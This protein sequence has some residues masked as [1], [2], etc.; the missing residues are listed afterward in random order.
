M[1]GFAAFPTLIPLFIAEWGLS[2]TDGGWITGIYFVGYVG[3][4]I[5]LTSLTDRKIPRDIY[6]FSTCIS[7][8]ACAGFA[9]FAEGF[10]TAMLFQALGGIG[11]AGTYMPGLKMLS[12]FLHGP[13][14]S[15]CIAFYTASFAI[16]TSVSILATG[17]LTDAMG[18]RGA[19]AML[20]LGPI[21][22]ILLSIRGIPRHREVT[23][24]RPATHMLDFRPVLRNRAA[25][26]YVMAYTVH[27]FELF[28]LRGWIV[29]FLVFGVSQHPDLNLAV[30]IA[31]IASMLNLSSVPASIFG[32][33][34]AVRMG[35]HRWATIVMLCSAAVGCTIGFA[36][37]WPLWG[38][39]AICCLYSVTISADSATIT[40]GAMES[41]PLGYKGATMAVYSS[42]AFTGSFLGPLTVGAVLDFS[43]G[44]QTTQSWGLA[45]MAVGLVV[46][47]GPLFLR[48]LGRPREIEL[49]ERQ[50]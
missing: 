21:C 36:S 25:M 22:A 39:I 4:V 7:A 49:K 16:G 26:A 13:K 33:E 37:A 15:R 42:V 28:A 32:N 29:A 24:Q 38:L 17:L 14:S 23:Q 6:V 1:A 3:A 45:F 41:A 18:W 27:N 43:G 30:S 11:L 8:L 31:F 20:S 9:L 47:T 40:A 44:G 48:W 10:W 12:D 34:F 50:Q 2:N 5:I 46:L 19:I 35:R